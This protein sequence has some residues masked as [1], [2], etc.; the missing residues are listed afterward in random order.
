MKKFITPT[1]TFTPGTSGVGTVNL[2]GVVDFDKKL[3]LSIINQTAG[4]IIYSTAIPSLGYTNVT[5]TTVTL[6]ADTS[7]QNA[8]DTLQVVYEES[9]MP[10]SLSGSVSANNT[11]FFV[12]DCADIRQIMFQ[13]TSIGGGGTISYQCC[14]EPTFATT[15]TQLAVN[16]SAG[17]N[18]TTTT[19]VGVFYINPNAR[20]IR[21]RT[22]AYTSGTLTVIGFGLKTPFNQTV[23]T[24]NGSLTSVSTVTTLANGQTAHSAAS[25]GSPLRVGGRVSPT[26]PA[27]VD[28]TLVANDASESY[29]TT[30]GQSITKDFATRE[31]DWQY[32]AA[33][34][35]INNT[36]TAVTIKAAS[37]TASVRNYITGLQISSSGL[38]AET[39]VAIRDGAGGTVI[40][41]CVFPNAAT[42]MQ[43]V[44]A[45]PIQQPTANSLLEVVTLTAVNGKIF[46]NAQGYVGP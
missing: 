30:S 38:S 19:T 7:A 13:V 42:T 45:T 3:L 11:D 4:V 41:R 44:L 25:T 18:S 9:D 16:P 27:T 1:Y 34:G 2:S 8:G 33:S 10:I 17:T 12:V 36:T 14:N 24:V 37:G 28:L 29:V 20:Y 31:L 22:T 39:E 21:L 23:Q 35:G 26:T 40:W 46:V 15:N 43:I 5:G 32:S 6:F